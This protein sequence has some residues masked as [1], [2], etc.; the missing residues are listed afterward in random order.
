MDQ[1]ETM[2]DIHEPIEGS[3]PVLALAPHARSRMIEALQFKPSDQRVGGWDNGYTEGSNVKSYQR[4]NVGIIEING[5]LW[6][7]D[8]QIAYYWG[9]TTYES[10]AAELGAMVN[11]EG[12]D[13]V[14]LSVNSPGGQVAGVNE[15]AGEIF[16]ARSDLPLGISAHVMGEAASAAY[17]I[18][19]AASEIV[20]DP[21][22]QLGSIGAVLGV[23]K[24][25]DP[26]KARSVE[27]VSSVSPLKRVDPASEA[28][29]SEYQSTV[30]A[31]GR[32]FVDTVARNRGTTSE[33]VAQDFGQ[34]GELVGIEA[35]NAGMAD[36]IG[37][38]ENV[39]SQMR[40][41]AGGAQIT[42]GSQMGLN[43]KKKEQTTPQETP[44]AEASASVEQPSQED[45]Q[46]TIDAERQRSA[47]ILD[48]L[49]GTGLE[50]SAG[51]YIAAGATIEKVNA[52]LV[53]HLKAEAAK[54]AP[55]SE[56]SGTLDA[57]RQESEAAA[58]VNGGNGGTVEE[59]QKQAEI[60]AFNQAWARGANAAIARGGVRKVEA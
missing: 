12:I 38:L 9:L 14:I 44:Q 6:T 55:A 24:S 47:A 2:I 40:S 13:G 27:F 23:Y 45:T 20:V 7:H 5:M 34:G 60:K 11:N 3:T 37:S 25:A 57:M 49:Q 54:P 15:L 42:E 4:G 51:E 46:V 32:V 17:W 59:D 43:T 16:A 29:A 53:A 58:Q 1:I 10:I 31:I 30:D 33:A 48:A 52:D 41:A 36:R 22:A 50:A 35:V 18:A 28:G 8:D 19:S 39:I 56:D 21:T 26:A